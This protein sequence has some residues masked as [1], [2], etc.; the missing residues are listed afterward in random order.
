M[1]IM[2]K[3]ILGL[4][5]FTGL[6]ACG[7]EDTPTKTEVDPIEDPISS[8]LLTSHEIVSAMS[9][10][11]NLGNTFDNGINSTSFSDIRPIINLY[12]TAGM[13]HIRIPITWMD[14][15][16][17][18]LADGNGNLNTDNERFKELV[19]VID[20]AISL[21]MYVV[22]NTHHEH[23]LKDNYDGSKS[24][25]DK[26]SNLWT[27]IATHFKDYPQTLIFEVLNEPEGKL[28]EWSNSG[29]WPNPSSGLALSYTRNVNQVGYDAIRAT[30]GANETRLVMISPNG[31]GNEAQ[32]DAVYPVVASL[33][34][35]G[36]DKYLS[37]QVHSYNPWAFCGQTGSNSAFPGNS[38]IAAAIKKTGTHAELLGVPINYGEFGVGR[39]SG[40]ERNT[41][42]VRGYY[43]TFSKTTLDENMSYSVW[44]DRGWFGLI[45]GS[46]SSYTFVNDIVP[47]MLTQ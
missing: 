31:Q 46:G 14:R 42:I 5:L 24:Y 15:F 25:D 18:N 12:Y 29:E 20:Y 39:T 21:D 4:F 32:I 3:Y 22:I 36:S 19:K 34:G 43:N 38:V 45:N 41:D 35:T 13:K 47:Q 7:E 17:S 26:F 27:N 33:P 9:H 30:G 23:W 16:T 2:L 28:G 37:I 40:T 11:F 1:K 44:D 10:G 8:D 6:I